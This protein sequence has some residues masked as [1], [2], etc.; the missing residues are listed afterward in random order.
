MGKAAGS[1]A[2]KGRR[3]PCRRHRRAGL[4]MSSRRRRRDSSAAV[5]GSARF[6]I[7]APKDV[8]VS[9]SHSRRK[10][11]TRHRPVKRRR[12][13][14]VMRFRGFMLFSGRKT[15]AATD[16]TSAEASKPR[17][18]P[19][20]SDSAV[21]GGHP[22][23]GATGVAR[24]S[25]RER[26]QRASLAAQR[27]APRGTAARKSRGRERGNGASWRCHA[28]E[29]G[30]TYSH[31]TGHHTCTATKTRALRRRGDAACRFR[32]KNASQDLR[33]VSEECQR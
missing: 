30:Y 20:L 1:R 11:A 29:C 25:R 14:R 28:G 13:K 12:K 18:F 5:S 16:S 32:A 17:R 15:A 31:S 24:S 26:R 3:R 4:R 33:H 22:S 9:D 19:G 27:E 8:S 7:C 21:P 2:A 23:G 6:V 10:S